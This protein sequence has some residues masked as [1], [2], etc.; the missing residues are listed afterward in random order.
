MDNRTGRPVCRRKRVIA[1]NGSVFHVSLEDALAIVTSRAY[2]WVI[3]SFSIAVAL[4]N[5]PM[6]GL[7]LPVLGRFVYWFVDCVVVTAGWLA[8]F[9]LLDWLERRTS[10]SP[11]YLSAMLCGA[12]IG[13]MIGVNYA[14]ERA[15]FGVPALGVWAVWG[16]WLRYFLI[17]VV[18][19]LLTVVFLLP[20]FPQAKFEKVTWRLGPAERPGGAVTQAEAPEEPEEREQEP[21]APAPGGDAGGIVLSGGKAMPLDGLM[22][23]KSVEH[24][25]EFAYRDRR[26]MER[27]TL[28]MLVDQI[29]PETG[30]R[31]HRSYWVSREAI[32]DVT[33][34]A[35]NAVLVL[36][37]GTEI[38]VSRNRRKAVS[39][40]L[41]A[42]AG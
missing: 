33:R 18:F 1:S 25:V 39:D 13:L 12:G 8:A 35:G 29:G 5:A 7:E 40:W 24:Y 38:P 41:K 27:A 28:R 32:S 36:E 6:F 30:I 11:P 34:K 21:E 20:S 16:E 26:E 42:Q 22:F 2:F 15:L 3:V 37:D 10:L 4:F 31:T 23:M 17:A 9:W 14:L 19:E